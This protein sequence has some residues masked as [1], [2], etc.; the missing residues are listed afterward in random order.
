VERAPVSEAIR[1]EGESMSGEVEAATGKSLMFA[2][3]L[4]AS[5]LFRDLQRGYA[6][7]THKG[8]DTLATQSPH[9]LHSANRRLRAHPSDP[10]RAEPASLA[11]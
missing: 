5:R 11:N 10:R 8:G 7:A 4:A 1:A 6:I 3:R 2:V 9:L